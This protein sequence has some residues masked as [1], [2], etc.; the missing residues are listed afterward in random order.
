MPEPLRIPSGLS[1]R[2]RCC[3][4]VVVF[5]LLS[6]FKRKPIVVQPHYYDGFVCVN[7][8]D[9]NATGGILLFHCCETAATPTKN[10]PALL[11]ELSITIMI[12]DWGL[13][14]ASAVTDVMA[15]VL[16]SVGPMHLCAF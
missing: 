9:V 4:G 10:V 6:R 2:R 14:M 16:H 13:G 12:D 8:V 1:G 5:R 15:I 11:D 7:V 3:A